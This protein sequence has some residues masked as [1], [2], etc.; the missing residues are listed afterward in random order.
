MVMPQGPCTQNL[1]SFSGNNMDSSSSCPMSGPLSTATSIPISELSPSIENPQRRYLH[2]VVIL[3][4]PFS[5]STKLFSLLLS[6][7]DFRLRSS[8]GQVKVSFRGAIAEA[9]AKS[10]IGIGDTV[11]LSLDGVEWVS[12]DNEISALARGVD[13]DLQFADRVLLEVSAFSTLFGR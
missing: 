3:L 8:K 2:A 10:R 6:E 4:W 1:P 5:S 13:W 9:V 7:P 12:R 11:F